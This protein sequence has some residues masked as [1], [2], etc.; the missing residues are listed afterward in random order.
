MR[1][2][3]QVCQHMRKI[4][5]RIPTLVNR[6]KDVITEKF[7][8]VAVAR[9]R[10]TGIAV[11]S[12]IC[13]LEACSRMRLKIYS[14]LSLMNPNL[15]SKRTRRPFSS[16]LCKSPSNL[17]TALCNMPSVRIPQVIRDNCQPQRC[18]HLQY[19]LASKSFEESL[20]RLPFALVS[21]ECIGRQEIFD[22]LRSHW[23]HQCV[24]DLHKIVRIV[25][26]NDFH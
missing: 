23:F 24:N 13:Q 19:E 1:N 15:Q 16:S 18:I 17:S 2:L 9:L 8:D 3:I 25:P 20:N 26:A 12:K 22:L 6:V 14:G 4:D 7:D 21:A 10:P 11:E 5:N